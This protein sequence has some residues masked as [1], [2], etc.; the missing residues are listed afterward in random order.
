MAPLV[1]VSVVCAQSDSTTPPAV[2]NPAAIAAKAKYDKSVKD[3]QDAYIKA[4]QTAQTEYITALDTARMHAFKA[5][6]ATEVE[7]L[8]K[9]KVRVQEEQKNLSPE[10]ALPVRTVNGTVKATQQWTKVIDV[11]KGQFVTIAA[12]GKWSVSKDRPDHV[13]DPDGL[14]ELNLHDKEGP[15]IAPYG[16]LVGKIGNGKAFAVGSSREFTV[17]EDGALHLGP[18]ERLAWLGDNVGELKITVTVK[19]PRK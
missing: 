3:A 17:Q 2:K 1:L 9:E 6:N 7:A 14:V 16:M 10:N 18:N 19:A 5:E 15:V 12:T 11:K 4:L 13:C 8:S